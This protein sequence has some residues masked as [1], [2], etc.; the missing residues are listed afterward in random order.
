MFRSTFLAP[1]HYAGK[2]VIPDEDQHYDLKAVNALGF[3]YATAP[4]SPAKEAKLLEVMECFHRYLMKY[5]CMIVRGTIPPAN[6]RA[7]RDAKELLRTLAA[8]GVKFTKPRGARVRRSSL[9]SRPARLF[10]GGIVPKELL[11]T[12]AP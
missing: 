12:L 10:A 1:S 5:L 11:R 7:G 3:A 9:A 4:D 2:W 8:R 6:S